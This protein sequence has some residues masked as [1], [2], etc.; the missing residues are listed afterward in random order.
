[1]KSI[2]IE[3]QGGTPPHHSPAGIIVDQQLLTWIRGH[4][5][6]RD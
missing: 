4:D 2:C 5:T 1:M 6:Q 3:S